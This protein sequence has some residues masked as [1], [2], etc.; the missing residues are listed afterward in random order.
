MSEKTN[1][2]A[3]TVLLVLRKVLQTE[4]IRASIWNDDTRQ[5]LFLEE[6]LL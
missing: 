5:L 4:C 2:I 6:I 1:D 3:P